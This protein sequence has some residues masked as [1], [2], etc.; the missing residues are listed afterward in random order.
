M[1]KAVKFNRRHFIKTTVGAGV[2]TAMAG[3][4]PTEERSRISVSQLDKAAAQPVL[5][6]DYF[7]SPV[8]IESIE[9]LYNGR[10]YMVRSRAKDGT[11][12]IAVTNTRA[13][14]LYPILNRLVIPFFI[15]KD[16]RDLDSLLFDVYRHNSN[17]KLSGLALWCCVAWVEFSLLD[18]LGK[19]AGKPVGDLIGK[20]IRSE[21][22]VYRASGHRDTTPEEEIEILKEYLEESGAKAVKFRVGGRMSNNADAMPGRTE[23]LIPL[24]RKE[25]GDDVA[26]HADANGSYDPPKGIEVGRML[27]DINAVFFEEP[28]PLD[29]LE[30]TKKVAD[31]LTIPIAFGEQETSLRR[32]R[33]LIQTGAAQIIQPDLHYNGGFIRSTRVARMAEV[34]GLPTTA[35]ISGGFGFVNMLQ[36][37]SW[38]PDIGQFQEYKGRV[39]DIGQFYDPVLRLKDGMINVPTGP[40]LG[41]THVDE[42]LRNAKKVV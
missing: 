36:F 20:K 19:M 28:C 39:S 10:Y 33:W 2:L 13:G 21:I 29:H 6:S 22:P 35:H 17:Y 41:L 24:T 8:K 32:F 34:A 12:G 26:I 30:D 37:A 14:Y 7:S 40:G 3:C 16:A 1:V 18:L 31:A 23:K 42:L 4:Q 5:K 25:L 27:E 11:V 38:T 9:L 15:D